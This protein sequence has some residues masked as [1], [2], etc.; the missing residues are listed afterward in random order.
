MQKI[1]LSY[2]LAGQRSAQALIRNPLMDLLQA[3]QSCGSIAGAARSLD[4]SYRHVWGELRRWEALLGQQLLVW[5]K[6]QK[7]V[8][9]DFGLKLLWAERQ[10]QARLAPQ[11]E[12]LRADLE[13]TFAV[14][15]DH[16]AHVMTLHASHDQALLALRDLGLASTQDKAHLDI[17]FTGSVDAIRD[18]ND[19][20]CVLAGFHVPLQP[21]PGSL[22]EKVYKPLLQTGQHKLI[23]F[24]ERMLGLM[25]A[26]GNPLGIHSLQDLTLPDRRFVNRPQGSGTRVLLDEALADAGLSASDLPGY[27]RTE[28]S[29]TAVAQAVATGQ[30]D[31]GLGTAL[32]AAS[33]GLGFVP[34]MREHYFLVCLKSALDTP[35]VQAL[36]HT[37]QTPVWQDQLAALPGYSPWRSGEV[38]SLR[39]TLP[40]WNF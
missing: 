40:W 34:L 7:A 28:T 39:R 38:L 9:S 11:I 2:T 31:A 12:A 13:R 22:T 5:E 8:L 23:G 26:P 33:R 16:H 4:L 19:G 10:A 3:V 15:F 24:A 29:H 21:K 18:L 36:L 35:S 27:A 32:A 14:A 25:V 30:A 37:L 17:R 1:E 20:R 6:G